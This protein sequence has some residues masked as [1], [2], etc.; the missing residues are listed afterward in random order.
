MSWPLSSRYHLS[1]YNHAS[2]PMDEQLAMQYREGATAVLAHSESKAR[3]LRLI[4]TL[5]VPL[6]PT[7]ALHSL[8]LPSGSVLSSQSLR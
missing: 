5:A 2:V 1:A 4:Y 6:A 7:S 3:R 8:L